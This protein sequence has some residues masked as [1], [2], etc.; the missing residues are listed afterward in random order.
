MRM[1]RW[2][3]IAVVA[4][5][6]GVFGFSFVRNPDLPAASHAEAVGFV[7]ANPISSNEWQGLACTHRRAVI[8]LVAMTIAP[9]LCGAKSDGGAMARAKAFSSK[10]LGSCWTLFEVLRKRANERYHPYLN[11][12]QARDKSVED[13]C[14]RAEALIKK[15]G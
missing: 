1:V 2:I 3:A 11:N 4:A 7:L 9:K 8:D 6:I 15:S 14:N 12:A 5:L 13:Y 10:G